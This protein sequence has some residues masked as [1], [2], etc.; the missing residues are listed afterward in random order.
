MRRLVARGAR[1]GRAVAIGGR[2]PDQLHAGR[3][4]RL[5]GFGRDGVALRVENSPR[6]C[7]G[8]TLSPRRFRH[9]VTRRRTAPDSVNDFGEHVSGAVVET[10]F[11]ASV[12]PLGVEDSELVGG[13]QLSER[14]VIYIPQPNA[15]VAAFDDGAA[16]HVVFDSVD[17]V[18]TDSWSWAGHTKAHVLR[19]T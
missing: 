7:G 18:V 5:A 14:R 6:W 2:H 17:F 1:V 15:L 16:D 10:A 12:Q 9:V 11:R 8:M 19:E 3:H 4:G 13:S